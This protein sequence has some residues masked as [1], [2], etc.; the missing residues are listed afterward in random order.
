[1]FVSADDKLERTSAK[2]RVRSC[3]SSATS[4]PPIGRSDDKLAWSAKAAEGKDPTKSP[5][6][7]EDATLLETSMDSV[8]LD[9]E[10]ERDAPE[11]VTY[12]Q[13]P[14]DMDLE[15][16]R[17]MEKELLANARALQRKLGIKGDA[18]V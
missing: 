12:Q 5:N 15:G 10:E 2:N 9:A 17:S 7:D 13:V 1:M 3:P 16:M 18:A 8:R 14:V 11:T 4:K 6:K